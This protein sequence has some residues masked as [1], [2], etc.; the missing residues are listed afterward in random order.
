VSG[1]SSD[2]RIAAV[3]FDFDGTLVLSNA[4][5][6]DTFFEVAAA[7][8]DGPE[9]MAAVLAAPDAGDRHRIFERFA[10]GLAG[11]PAATAQALVERYSSLCERRI[12]AAPSRSGADAL[13]AWLHHR[14]LPHFICSA[15]PEA[16]LQRI[17][18][19][20][21]G[22]TA[23]AGVMG[24][25][26]S[27]EDGLMLVLER[28]RLRP[29]SLL[30]VGDGADDARAAAAVGCAFAA[31]VGQGLSGGSLPAGAAE[32][33]GAVQGWLADAALEPAGSADTIDAAP[34][35]G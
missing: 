27:K 22:A 35:R 11:A 4:I 24:A 30:H 13:L 15:T 5:K 29:E 12:L 14:R 1:P 3:V 21:Y 2:A 17:V 19:R 9:R 25:P 10:A 7:F 6:R 20:R 28:L 26:R 23:F 8:P 31:V 16:P 32:D 34:V 33:L 18:A